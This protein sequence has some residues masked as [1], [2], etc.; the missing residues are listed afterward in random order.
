MKKS[1]LCFCLKDNQVLLAMKKIG[2]G[3]GKWNGFGGKVEINEEPAAAAIRELREESGLITTEDK[4]QKVALINF[5]FE[6]NHVF[7]C[8]VYITHSWL[9]EP[10]ETEEMKPCWFPAS[11]LPFDEMWAADK[12]WIPLVLDGEKIKVDINFNN[13]GS[14]VKSFTS[15]PVVFN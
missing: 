12:K 2:F 5:L 10:V 11:T 13:D 3:A 7:E 9:G 4:L 6:G 14:I 8:H 1:T 15:E